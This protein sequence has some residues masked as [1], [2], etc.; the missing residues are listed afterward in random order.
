MQLDEIKVPILGTGYSTKTSNLEAF[1]SH[2][3]THEQAAG[4]CYVCTIA[5][6]YRNSLSP[7]RPFPVFANP[8][9]LARVADP[10]GRPCLVRLRVV[11]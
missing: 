9:H 1:P 5:K 11:W 8:I 6:Y 7:S 2:L 4:S 10:A 3:H